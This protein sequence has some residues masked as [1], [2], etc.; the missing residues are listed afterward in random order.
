M[1]HSTLLTFDEAKTRLFNTL[2]TTPLTETIPLSECT[3][4]VVAEDIFSPHPVPSFANSAMDGFAVRLT[5][6]AAGQSLPIAGIILAGD[7]APSLWP[8]QSCF[9]IMTGAPLPDGTDAVVMLEHTEQKDSHIYFKKPVIYKQNIRFPGEDIAQN[10][11]I[12]TKGQRLTIPLLSQ[13]STLGIAEVSVFKRIRVALFSTG[14]ELLSLGSA[15]KPGKIYDSNRLT[16]ILLLQQLGCDIIDLGIIEDNERKITKTLQEA[17]L[18]ADIIITSGGVSVGDA[19]YIKSAVTALGEIDFWKIAIK[20]GKPF[21]YGRI[22]TAIFCGLPGNPL[23]AFTVF[24]HLIQ[25]LILHASGQCNSMSSFPA[26]QVRS[27]SPLHKKIGRMDFHR[28]RLITNSQ[29]ELCV[30]STGSQHSHL[31]R[32]LIQANCFIILEANR[33]NVAPGEFVTVEPFN[34]LIA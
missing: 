2:F 5:D 10:E 23:S 31:T 16:L 1:S 7:T 4:R 11:I 14:N 18:N 21:A 8:T 6:L 12:A 30:E 26:F 3:N 32:S 9:K 28:G 29:G 15:P 22:N 25:P 24:Y 17:A 20:P 13:L 19:D 27:L 33:S 34:H